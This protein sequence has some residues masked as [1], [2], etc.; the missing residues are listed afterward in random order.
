MLLLY[1]NVLDCVVIV[2]LF[3]NGSVQHHQG[4][5]V[6]PNQAHV[7]TMPPSVHAK[8]L[9]YLSSV[10]YGA[11][12][13]GSVAKNI[14]M[15]S[16]MFAYEELVEATG[17]FSEANLLGEGGF[18]YVHKGVLK[19]GRE[20]AVKQLK[21][22]SYQG[23]REFQAEVDTISRVHHKHLVSLVGYCING[24]KRLLVYEFV[25]KDTLEFHLHGKNMCDLNPFEDLIL[26]F[27]F[28]LSHFVVCCESMCCRKQRKCVGMGNEA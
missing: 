15:P 13:N 5:N 8:P 7:I 3:L 6:A 11:K 17:G 19:N 26:S 20:V 10:S 2:R 4:G 1:E 28:L 21:I 16:G 22:G 9:E 12:E 24:D 14:T 27:I 25:P 18:G 23:E